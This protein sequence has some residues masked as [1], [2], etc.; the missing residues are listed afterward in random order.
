MR[1]RELLAAAVLGVLRL[2]LQQESHLRGAL[3]CGATRGEI[4]AVLKGCGLRVPKA[5]A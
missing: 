1:E 2:P 5:W 4:R 3:R